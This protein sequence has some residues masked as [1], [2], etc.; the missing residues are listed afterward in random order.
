MVVSLFRQSCTIRRAP[1][2]RREVH[3]RGE[4]CTFSGRSA[5][6][7]IF[8]QRKTQLNTDASLP[9]DLYFFNKQVCIFTSTNRS[10]PGIHQK[11]LRVRLLSIQILEI[12]LSMKT[13]HS[14]QISSNFGCFITKALIYSSAVPNPF[15]LSLTSSFVGSSTRI[16]SMSFLASSIFFI[17]S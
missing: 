9:L 7:G 17:F 3:G 6:K 8:H 11:L 1:K 14:G 15:N 4:N 13:F 16:S 12:L 2:N 10:D 5:E